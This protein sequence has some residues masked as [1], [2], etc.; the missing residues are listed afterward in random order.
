MCQQNEHLCVDGGSDGSDYDIEPEQASGSAPEE[1]VGEEGETNSEP[2]PVITMGSFARYTQLTSVEVLGLL[3]SATVGGPYFSVHGRDTVRPPQVSRYKCA[4]A[5]FAGAVS[6]GLVRLLP[7][8]PKQSTL[9][10]R[11]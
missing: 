4:S 3:I 9:S 1:R 2:L 7:V 6:G 8:R 5:M 11:R 10:Q